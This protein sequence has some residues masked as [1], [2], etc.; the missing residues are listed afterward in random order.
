MPLLQN[1]TLATLRTKLRTEFGELAGMDTEID[2]KIN[3]ALARV[4]GERKYH[5]AIKR[6]SFLVA[7]QITTT[8]SGAHTAGTAALVLAS[9]TGLT[10]RQSITISGGSE[11]YMSNSVAGATVTLETGL[12]RALSGGETVTVRT[13]WT[14]LPDDFA[15]A[16][17]LRI[18]GIG[19]Q[20]V[21]KRPWALERVRKKLSGVTPTQLGFFT[22]MADPLHY[23]VT[24]WNP[25]RQY[26]SFWP[27]PTTPFKVDGYYHAVPKDLSVD[28]DIPEVPR[29]YRNRLFFLAAEQVAAKLRDWEAVQWYQVKAA[30]ALEQMGMANDFAEET[31]GPMRDEE[32]P[33]D[34]R[35]IDPG[36][37]L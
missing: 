9:G 37:V 7:G 21:Y 34:L 10:A 32:T 31:D 5:W 15:Y 18:D 12:V 4:W 19:T 35:L 23:A 25:D 28:G 26:I 30:E 3:L 1:Y 36:Q 13:M 33:S 22:V 11:E 6:L 8:V 27:Q 2:A 20:P 24:G 16:T 29:G 14:A 17:T